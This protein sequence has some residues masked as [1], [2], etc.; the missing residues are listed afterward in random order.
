MLK[1]LKKTILIV[2]LPTLFYFASIEFL[3]RSIPNDYAYKAAID[4]KIQN[5]LQHCCQREECE[6][7]F[8][9]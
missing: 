1:F 5:T 2:L 8:Y 9:R 6:R 3:V 4:F 7:R